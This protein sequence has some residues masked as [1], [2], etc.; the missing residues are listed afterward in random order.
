MSHTETIS[1]VASPFCSK[2]AYEAWLSLPAGE[3]RAALDAATAAQA[4]KQEVKKTKAEHAFFC[5]G[6]CG[7]LVDRPWHCGDSGCHKLGQPLVEVP[8]VY[9]CP[10]CAY[11]SDT[12]ALCG[13][14][15]SEACVAVGLCPRD[16]TLDPPE[17]ARSYS[18]VWDSNEI[19]EG[20]A[21]SA[22]GSAQ[23]WSAARNEAGE[24]AVLDA[25]SE[26]QLVGVVVAGRQHSHTE[27]C[28]TKL[29]VEVRTTPAHRPCAPP[30]SIAPAHRLCALP[31]STAR[32]LRGHTRLESRWAHPRL[33]ACAA[34]HTRTSTPMRGRPRRAPMRVVPACERRCRVTARR[35]SL[36]RTVRGWRRGL[37]PTSRT[38]RGTCASHSRALATCG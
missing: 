2:V 4:A 10:S 6:T 1:F 38:R 17:E 19:G 23:A 20:H 22:L 11:E 31:L 14:H 35:G 13:T 16:T 8:V 28:V 27:Q 25:G 36:R 37:H 34:A 30:L 26:L 12:P 9:C 15:T 32:P 24:W 18:S 21:R 7:G 5:T 33:P 29:R 3:Q